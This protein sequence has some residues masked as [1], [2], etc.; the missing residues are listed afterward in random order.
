MVENKSHLPPPPPQKRYPNKDAEV[1]SPIVESDAK[2]LSQLVIRPERRRSNRR[3]SPA[4]VAQEAHET[5]GNTESYHWQRSQK[6]RS[7]R[8]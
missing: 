3:S 8:L 2:P 6:Y 4:I 5:N 1:K 7:I